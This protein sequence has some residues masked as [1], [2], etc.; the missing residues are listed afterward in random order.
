MTEI[1]R[2][3]FSKL[4]TAFSFLAAVPLAPI[5]E[6]VYA[7]DMEHYFRLVEMGIEAHEILDGTPLEKQW[8]RMASPEDWKPL[9]GR[10]YRLR[11]NGNPISRMSPFSFDPETPE[12]MTFS[13]YDADWKKVIKARFKHGWGPERFTENFDPRIDVRKMVRVDL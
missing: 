1:S 13:E 4:M 7:I 2:R 9:V 6:R 5:V 11:P 8:V 3:E 12:Y 10:K